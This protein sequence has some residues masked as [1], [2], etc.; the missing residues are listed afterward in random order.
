MIFNRRVE[1]KKKR[2]RK[3]FS[4]FFY[5]NHLLK[6]LFQTIAVNVC[7]INVIMLKLEQILLK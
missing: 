5:L 1:F 3:I 7:F 6:R 2:L 4:A